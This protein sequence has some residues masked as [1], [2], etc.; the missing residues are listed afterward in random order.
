[1]VL[2]HLP[3][4]HPDPRPPGG[5]C[6]TPREGLLSQSAFE[7]WPAHLNSSMP[8]LGSPVGGACKACGSPDNE[9]MTADLMGHVARLTAVTQ[10]Q[11]EQLAAAD[12]HMQA[13]AA[14]VGARSRGAAS[15]SMSA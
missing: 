12:S 8:R 1:M 3:L 11:R 13:L 10:R 14:R 7:P 4:E 15:D 9:T 2:P 5:T 6:D